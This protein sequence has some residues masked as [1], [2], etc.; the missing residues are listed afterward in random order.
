MAPRSR[1]ALRPTNNTGRVEL[2]PLGVGPVKRT[3]SSVGD[4]AASTTANYAVAAIKTEATRRTKPYFLVAWEGWTRDEHG[5]DTV[6][7]DT[8]EPIEHL[9]GLEEVIEEFCIAAKKTAAKRSPATLVRRRG[10]RRNAKRLCLQPISPHGV[11]NFNLGAQQG[12]PLRHARR[13]RSG[14]AS[15]GDTSRR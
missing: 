9:A 5:L 12:T 13:R 11:N 1:V 15:T 3:P 6:Q 4:P 8:W 2:K 14:L 7:H 10:R